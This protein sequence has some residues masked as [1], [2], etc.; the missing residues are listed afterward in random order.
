VHLEISRLKL[1]PELIKVRWKKHVDLAHL[2]T[3]HRHY[4]GTSDCPCDLDVISILTLFHFPLPW[5]YLLTNAR[6]GLVW[7][8][9]WENNRQGR[10]HLGRTE[11]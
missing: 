8:N 3:S 4:I 2:T 9:S 5:Q 6:A 1:R 11:T 10:Q 7:K